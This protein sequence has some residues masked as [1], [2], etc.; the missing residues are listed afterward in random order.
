MVTTRD[1]RRERWNTIMDM[2][3]S[4]FRNTGKPVSS[5][6][7]AAH[8]NLDLCPATIRNVMKELEDEGY[9]SQPHTSAGR[10]PT[11]KGYRYYVDYLMPTPD[12]PEYQAEHIKTLIEQAIRENDADVFLD[13]IAQMLSEVTDLVGVAM[14]PFLNRCVFERLDIVSL[15]G[16]R[17][18]LVISLK[19]GLVRTI[20][21]TLDHV[22]ARAKI[23][24]TA[25]FLSNRLG[26]L[27]IGEIKRTIGD[28]IKNISGGDRLLI[29]V[30]LDHREQ[31]FTAA[32]EG[33]IHVSGISRLLGLPEFSDV[34]VSHKLIGLSENKLRISDLFRQRFADR[35]G[36]TI[37]IG[38]SELLGVSVPL[39][40]V[41]ATWFSG[42]TPGIVGV[43]GPT[44]ID[45]SRV[46]AV[47]K[48]TASVTTTFFSS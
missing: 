29:D 26:G 12:L 9:L 20:N 33:D 16:T 19:N 15:G 11:V 13:H 36:F 46:M 32:D 4:A 40:I 1:K 7:V 41:A 10:I 47:I 2:I 38:D 22:V 44:R 5:S 48:H 14:T 35:G 21:L 34:T 24:E 23:G 42:G 28:R 6:Y 37:D 3:I 30:I 18:L 43:I 8:C 45:Y 39:S 27:T 17:Y 31:I 25:R